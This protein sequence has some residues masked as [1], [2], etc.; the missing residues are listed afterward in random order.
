M[1]SPA[2]NRIY[3]SD[4]NLNFKHCRKRAAEV[5]PQIEAMQGETVKMYKDLKK[6]QDKIGMG[7]RKRK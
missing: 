2:Q 4:L 6:V 7:R 3:I 1:N 5:A